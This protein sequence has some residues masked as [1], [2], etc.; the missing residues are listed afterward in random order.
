MGIPVVIKQVE[1]HIVKRVSGKIAQNVV[2]FV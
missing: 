1:P 2:I